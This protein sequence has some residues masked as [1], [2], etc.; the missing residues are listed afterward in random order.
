[1]CPYCQSFDAAVYVEP[2]LLADDDNSMRIAH[3]EIFGPILIAMPFDDDD[4]VAITNDSIYALSGSVS[5]A[6][7]E[8]ALAV[9]RRTQAGTVGV[10]GA[11]WCAADSARRG[12]QGERHRSP[13]R[14][15]GFRDVPRGQDD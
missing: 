2:T 14:A 4:A 15:R 9:A 12:T 3:D 7:N 5:A 8:R 13:G 1:M 11:S 6:S 10:H